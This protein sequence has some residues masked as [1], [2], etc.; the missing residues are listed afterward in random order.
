MSQPNFRTNNISGLDGKTKGDV[1]VLVLRT[2]E[3]EYRNRIQHLEKVISSMTWLMNYC[4]NCYIAE[5]KNNCNRDYVF[6]MYCDK[7]GYCQDCIIETNFGTFTPDIY[8]HCSWI[9]PDC[10]VNHLKQK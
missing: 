6:C 3:K 4:E 8:G 7:R 2:V 9:C 10:L 5:D 1:A